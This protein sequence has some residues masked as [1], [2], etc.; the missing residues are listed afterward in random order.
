[1]FRS[2]HS[3][4]TDALSASERFCQQM[5]R[6]EAKNFY[7]GFIALPREQRTAIYAL[8][9]FARQVDDE[10]DLHDGRGPDGLARH[11]LRLDGCYAGRT[12]DPVMYLLSRVVAR[13]AIPREELEAIISGAAQDLVTKRYE[14]WDDL[15]SY[16]RLV[17]SSIGRMCVRIFGF[18]NPIA[19]SLADELGLALQLTNILR[20]VRE[21]VGMDRVYLPRDD[22]RRFGVAE[23]A[24]LAGDPGS[25]WPALIRFEVARAR[26]LFE[27]GLAVTQHIPRRPAACVLTMAGIYRAILEQI[28]AAPYLPLER[29]AALD[30]RAKLAVMLRSWVSAA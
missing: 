17:A 5:T 18:D 30:R 24:L 12:D 8:Y 7:W 29:R 19:L 2:P 3:V 21:D 15:E 11:R 22:L 9:D 13:Y 23:Q 16:G 26:T 14:S 27:S 4:T 6:R 25:G 1:M 28:Y 20:D 10:A